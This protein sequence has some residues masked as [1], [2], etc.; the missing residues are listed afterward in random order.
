MLTFH[1]QGCAETKRP[2]VYVRVSSYREWIDECLSM[3]EPEDGAVMRKSSVPKEE[4]I[5]TSG[6]SATKFKTSAFFL[7]ALINSL[8]SYFS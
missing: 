6:E 4:G 2:G 5:T 1:F 7:I 3:P 8:Y